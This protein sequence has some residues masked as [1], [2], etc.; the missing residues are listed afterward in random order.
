MNNPIN[1]PV[2][3]HRGLYSL[4]DLDDDSIQRIVR[5]TIELHTDRA[6]HTSPLTGLVT[7]LLFTKTSTRT[8]TAFTTAAIRLGGAPLAFGPADLQTNTGESAAD[9]GRMLAGM[10]DLLVV[11][12]AGPMQELRELSGGGELPVVNAMSAEEHP[13]QGL[14]DLATLIHHFGGLDGIRV[15]YVGEGNNTAVALARVLSRQPGCHA[16]FASPAGYGLPP[17]VLA[18]TAATA[19][20]HHGS[21][22]EVHDMAGVPEA[23]RGAGGSGDIHAVYTSRWQTTGSS[24]PDPHWR[25][26]FRPFHVGADLMDRLPDA[27][28]LHDLPAHR[29]EEVSGEVLD[30]KSSLAWTQARMKAAG[31]MAVLEWLATT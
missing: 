16:V 15:L 21:V 13:T 26:A 31:A 3:S 20:R 1:G 7:G 27:V 12:T 25:D 18:E 17:A 5:R 28:F 22:T 4:A 10:L 11:R 6:A 30:G 24:K 23:A 14:A 2:N 19:A 29:G 9:T 8:R